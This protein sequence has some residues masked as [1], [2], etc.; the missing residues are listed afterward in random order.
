MYVRLFVSDVVALLLC[1]L[2]IFLA[3]NIVNVSSVGGSRAV[4][5]R[6]VDFSF[7]RKESMN[8]YFSTTERDACLCVNS[9]LLLK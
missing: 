9:H 4:S 3:G 6:L 7:F 2:N 1:N 5:T 8:W